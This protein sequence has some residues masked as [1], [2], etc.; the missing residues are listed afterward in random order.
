M[1]AIRKALDTRK[2]KTVSTDSLIKLAECVL[3]NDIF[4][5]DKSVFK[6]LRGTAIGTKMGPPYAIIFMDSLEED[7]LGNTILKPV[8]C[9]RYTGDIFMMLEHGEEELKK[10]LENLNCFHPTIKFTAECSRTN[11]NSLDLTVM[12]KGNQLVTDLYVKPADTHQYLHASSCHVSHCK[13]QQYLPA[14][15]CVLTEFLLFLI[16]DVMN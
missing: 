8:V 9:W 4:E 5:H 11:V 7:M 16:N 1:I 3:K 15:P 14:K 12:K 2:D 13:N 6:Q 10:V